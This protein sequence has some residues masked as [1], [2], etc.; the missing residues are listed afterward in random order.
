MEDMWQTC[1]MQAPPSMQNCFIGAAVVAQLQDDIM[2]KNAWLM[3]PPPPPARDA[4]RVGWEL[5]APG[6]R[7]QQLQKAERARKRM[8]TTLT[9][10][11]PGHGG[12]SRQEGKARQ[13]ETYL[14]AVAKALTSS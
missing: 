4:L 1:L 10:R 14:T 13:W 11:P 3:D 5:F 7:I 9:T 12:P 2:D 6:A 8:K